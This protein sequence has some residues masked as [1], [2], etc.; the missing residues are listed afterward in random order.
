MADINVRKGGPT[1][2][3]WVLGLLVLALMIWALTE[4]FG[5]DAEIDIPDPIADTVAITPEG[6]APASSRPSGTAAGG[7]GGATTDTLGGMGDTL[8]FGGIPGR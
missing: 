8:Q 5:E 4:V 3:P 6:R 7:T 1:I 2:W